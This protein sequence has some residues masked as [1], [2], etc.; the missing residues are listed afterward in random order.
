M[1][2][3]TTK[4]EPKSKN[5]QCRAASNLRLNISER[6]YVTSGT[7]ISQI[8]GE[9]EKGG[10]NADDG[11]GGKK[12]AVKGGGGGVTP[13]SCNRLKSEDEAKWWM[14]KKIHK[15]IYINTP[16]NVTKIVVSDRNHIINYALRI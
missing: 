9:V 4:N 5:K 3:S 10:G 13:V 6:V 2:D 14:V 8:V 11:G 16:Q 12:E 7:K 1:A 15:H